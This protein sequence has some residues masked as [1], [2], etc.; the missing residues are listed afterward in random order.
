MQIWHMIIYKKWNVVRLEQIM[1]IT[2][3]G[4]RGC[5][6]A[7][8]IHTLVSVS[9]LFMIRIRYHHLYNYKDEVHRPDS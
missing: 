1:S 9:K 7:A 5:Q 8:A 2:E 4:L 3:N 6:P